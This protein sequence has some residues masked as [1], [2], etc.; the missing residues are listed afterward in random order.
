[1]DQM[2]SQYQQFLDWLNSQQ[3]M[4]P[5][6]LQAMQSIIPAIELYNQYFA[7]Q[8]DM[9]I[10]NNNKGISDNNLAMSGNDVLKSNNDLGVSNNNKSISDNNV[11]MSGNDVLRSNN[12]VKISGD[13]VTKSKNSALQSAYNTQSA[14]YGAQ[15]ALYNYLFA[16]GALPGSAQAKN[17][18]TQLPANIGY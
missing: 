6:Q 15:Q 2:Q 5:E 4:T 3:G 16:V 9:G 10:S 12:D 13:D 11:V 17:G 14:S 18:L 7:S 8:N 1:M